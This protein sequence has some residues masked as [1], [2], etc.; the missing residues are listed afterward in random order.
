MVDADE[1]V[2]EWIVADAAAD[3]GD[4]RQKSAQALRAA[5]GVLGDFLVGTVAVEGARRG[6]GA[7]EVGWDILARDGGVCGEG[8]GV[9]EGGDWGGNKSGP[10]PWFC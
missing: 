10:A 6:G 8:E 9:V 4:E 7:A 3:V 5:G 2:P 1:P